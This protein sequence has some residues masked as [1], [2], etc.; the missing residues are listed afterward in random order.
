MSENRRPA[1]IAHDSD[2]ARRADMPRYRPERIA[3]TVM[4][5]AGPEIGITALV[6]GAGAL[7]VHPLALPVVAVLV[8]VWAVV[9]R[10]NRRKAVEGSESRS[11]AAKPAPADREVGAA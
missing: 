8:T 6:G 3:S 9:D 1:P 10:T 4:Y 11:E 5:H 2:L 7:I